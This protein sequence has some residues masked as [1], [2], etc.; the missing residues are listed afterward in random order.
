MKHKISL[1]LHHITF[2]ALN[3]ILLDLINPKAYSEEKK[4]DKWEKKLSSSVLSMVN[5]IYNVIM[6]NI[7]HLFHLI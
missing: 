1:Q 6:L 5:F 3:I 4:W 2:K 7:L